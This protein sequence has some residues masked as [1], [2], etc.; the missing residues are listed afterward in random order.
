MWSLKKIT[1]YLNSS[2][3]TCA[4]KKVVKFDQSLAYTPNPNK[5]VILKATDVTKIFNLHSKKKRKTVINHLNLTIYDG[6]CIALVGKNGAGKTTL[7]EMFSGVLPITM[8]NINFGFSYLNS[9]YEKLGVQFQTSSYPTGLAVKDII[10]FLIE[11]R[12]F[13]FVDPN[14]K[15][16]MIDVF[17]LRKLMNFEANS[18]SGGQKQRLNIFLALVSRPQLIFLDE[19]TTG[20]DVFSQ[21]KILNYIKQYIQKHKCTLICISHN[22]LEIEK[23]ANRI[24]FL[25]NG[26]ISID[27]DVAKIL[28]KY[29]DISSFV[30]VHL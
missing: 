29:K 13:N 26:K 17:N 10:N 23:L 1:K 14:E 2:K 25:E 27:A 11:I 5:K 9:P 18:L 20:L 21:K 8:G 22:I 19:L 3:S 16:E 30:N 12:N 24:I 15:E 4:R 7:I 6:D 28:K